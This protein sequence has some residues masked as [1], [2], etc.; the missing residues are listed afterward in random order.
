MGK[1]YSRFRAVF[2]P[3]SG[4]DGA[5]DLADSSTAHLT[6][7]PKP[8]SAAESTEVPS[9]QV[10]GVDLLIGENGVPH[11]TSEFEL[12]E[13]TQDAR[14]VVRRGQP[15][16][17]KL[18][19][20]RALQP[21]QDAVSFI[22]TLHGVEKPTHG[23]GTLVALPLLAAGSA[24]SS[25]NAWSATIEKNLP[26]SK[27][28]R[29]LI[30]PS[31][32]SIVGQWIMEVDTKRQT[33]GGA[34]SYEYPHPFFV[35]FNPWCKDDT[36]YLESE[37]Q[38][39]EYVLNDTGLIWRGSYN[40]LRP[41]V[42][43]YAHFERDVLECSLY[44]TSVIGKLS[45]H[46]RADPVRTSRAISAAVNSPDD[47][48][49]VM[50]NWSD[51]YSGGTAPIKWVGSLQILQQFWKTKKPVKYG[52]CWVFAG[53]VSTICRALGIPSRP[54]TNY[55][56]AHDTQ[57]SLT[58]D[59]F[60]NEKAEIM[61][62]LNSDSIW[63]FHVW[64]EAWMARPDL[65]DLYSGWQVIDATPQEQSDEMYRCGP[66]SVAAIKR[67]EVLKQFD[68]AFVYAEVNADKVYWRYNGPTQPLKLLRKDMKG[69]GR[70]ISTKAVGSTFRDD[71][72]EFYKYP[73]ESKE[74]RA[75][76]LTALR[77]S[78]SLFSRYYLNEDFNDLH[79]DFELRDDIVIGMPFSVVLVMK[80]R[81]RTMDYT[82]VVTL[83]VDTVTYTGHVKDPVK[84]DKTERL[85]KG[86]AVEEIR[87]DVSYN[88]YTSALVDQASFNIA[89]MA[90][91]KDT[92]YEYFAQDDFRVRKP[93]IKFKL[94][95]EPVEGQEVKATISLT[96]PLPVPLRKG[97][98]SVEGPGLS[99]LKLK[100]AEELAPQAVGSADF[101]FTPHFSGKK[102]L[103]AK[104]SSRELDDVDGFLEFMIKPA[105]IATTEQPNGDTPA[106]AP[107][108]APEH[109]E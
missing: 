35:L 93:D 72:T 16:V 10:L 107:I 20:N 43:H 50:G 94:A 39:Q 18:S 22:F 90:S 61:E 97:Q 54:V 103:S 67:G 53:V 75:A 109:D 45:P 84:K 82:V 86:G 63:N 65:G 19:F 89:C 95:N 5:A 69:I 7:L 101:V 9:L 85:V 34:V 77:Q 46:A 104:F 48:G 2:K 60:V 15:F 37:P 83:R 8:P 14:L 64:N 81:S 57:S 68:G 17:L 31:A 12:M 71:I 13:R 36:V 1:C 108:A 47:N 33:E 56:S 51:D 32:D 92:Q 38:R 87:M 25:P 99:Q 11:H 55:S 80:N 96:N 3:N 98:F 23:H 29:V 73:E 88:D 100:L 27:A 24:P 74:E 52:Q 28:V 102:T 78:A 70:L 44:L 49:A 106:G 26:D 30:T 105:S 42:W 58:V 79:F 21:A 66:S 59:Y 62:E 76:M 91:V 4:T 40:R 41:S 6:S